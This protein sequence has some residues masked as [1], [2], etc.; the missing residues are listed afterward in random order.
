MGQENETTS[1]GGGFLIAETGPEGIFTPED[2][3][4]E[5]RMIADT[6]EQFMESEVVPRIDAIEYKE[7]GINELLLRKAGEIGLLA[8]TVPEELGGAG[9][10]QV[11]ATI[12]SD[13]SGRHGSFATTFGAH[14]GIGTLPIL[15]FGTEDQKKKYLPRLATADWISAY[16]LTEAEAGS[17]ALAARTRAELSA[18]GKK[19]LLNGTKL[20]ITNAGFA[21]IFVTFAKVDGDKFTAFIVERDAPGVS[22]GPEEH[23]MGIN[24]SSTRTLILENA[25]VPVDNLLGEIGRGHVIAFNI[26]NFGRFKLGASVVSGIKHVFNTALRY[27]LSRMQFQ[28]PIIEFGAIQHKIAEMAVRVYAAESMVY[29]TAGLIDSAMRAAHLT[30]SSSPSSALKVLEEYAVECSVVKVANS[31]ILD[32]VVDEAVQIHGGNGF[33]R[34]YEV[35]RCYR[36]AR[37]NRIFEGTNEINRLLISGML[38]KRSM[39]GQLGILAAAQKIAGEL[40]ELSTREGAEGDVLE[41]ETTLIRN[42]RKIFLL[43]AGVAAKRFREA[44]A[45]QQEIL[46]ALSTIAIH[47]YAAESTVLRARKRVARSAGPDSELAVQVARIVAHNAFSDVEKQARE[48]LCACAEGDEL[49]TQLAALRRFL[50][51]TG[52][53]LIASRR[54]VAEALRQAERY[55]LS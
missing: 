16:A 7:S 49:R 50:R 26:L 39:K 18:D 15:Y 1:P 51:I 13:K 41:P 45:E 30:E 47:L 27:A 46:C 53:D 4:D 36:D 38:L 54:R 17:D 40:L 12:I 32:F 31:E 44:L 52:V 37:V 33:S 35:E 14:S 48:I 3:S 43:A 24:G 8:P 9:L 21:H 20:W 23:K 28:K 22:T 19:Y 42:Y 5:H 25:E 2:F 6:A 11:S 55:C 10:D 34:D 29:R